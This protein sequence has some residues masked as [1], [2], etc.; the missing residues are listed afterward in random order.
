MNN[1]EI[2]T[3]LEKEK[4][5]KIVKSFDSYDVFYL[6]EYAQAFQFNGDGKPILFYYNDGKTRAINVTMKREI[7]K[8]DKTNNKK[9]YDLVSPYGYGGFVIEG[10]DSNNV[11]ATYDT[12]C[13]EN[14]I[15]CEF[16]RF[17][18]FDKYQEKYNGKVE[19]I[20]HNVIRRINM[21]P[22]EMIMDFEHKVRKNLK[23]A[24]NN[25][26][27][28]QIDETGK[29]LNEF[30]QIYYETMKRNE[31]KEEYYFKKDFFEILNTMK[32]NIVYFN[33]IHNEKIISTELVIYAKNNAYSYLGGTL[34]QYFALRPN[35]FL[36]YEIIKWAY[37]K[38]I[39]NF[40]LG[41]G[42]GNED[43]GIYRYKKS[44]APNDG[45]V[46][47][48]I[49]KKI[50]NNVMYDKLVDIRKKDEKFDINSEFFPL[51]RS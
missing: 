21:T 8:K 18:L 27:Q 46:D 2:I 1:Y 37:K 5:N 20:K 29:T 34:S 9:Y 7:L 44:L 32:E 12:W 23:K 42:Y 50:F 10:E 15:V 4:W 36:K 35:D 43:D 28:I 30:L 17:N 39:R 22:E 26:L 16:I 41:G 19:N 6:A 31:A 51:Y 14:D 47:F 11:N 45:E 24:E 49:G 25:G 48:F 33:V 13:K 40:V 38:G 3:L